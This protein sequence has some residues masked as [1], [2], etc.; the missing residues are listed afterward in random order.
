[1]TTDH[2]VEGSNP[3]GRAKFQVIIFRFSCMRKIIFAII[4][5]IILAF[6]GNF[7]AWFWHTRTIENALSN[8]QRELSYRNIDIHYDDIHYGQFK[9]WQVGGILENVSIKTKGAQSSDIQF[10]EIKFVSYPLQYK[11]EFKPVGNVIYI[12][13]FNDKSKVYEVSYDE[14]QPPYIEMIFNNSLVELEEVIKVNEGLSFLKV[15][16][17]LNYHDNGL[18]FFDS[19]LNKKY[20]SIQGANL[21]INGSREKN[22]NNINFLFSVEEFKY[23][24][25]YEDA[26]DQFHNYLIKAQKLYG[27]SS[28]Y[29][30]FAV[31][32]HASKKTKDYIA[33]KEVETNSKVENEAIFDA[34]TIEIA[35]IEI[36]NDKYSVNFKGELTKEPGL[37]LPISNV[38]LE[39]NNYNVFVNDFVDTYNARFQDSIITKPLTVEQR[40]KLN[41]FFSQFAKGVATDIEMKIV[42]NEAETSVSGKPINDV[43]RDLSEIFFGKK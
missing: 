23:D 32:E 37:F 19:T 31:K 35:S 41:S 29:F 43:I 24:P 28:I 9:S 42:L 34:V 33:Q 12:A 38:E 40:K 30:N 8:L 15:I 13:N 2:E 1:M 10:K 5:L 20:L 22:S 14:S 11:V 36:K 16:N 21:M 25:A 27:P 4:S 7:V 3:S 6:I 39:I 18:Q 17:K 26:I